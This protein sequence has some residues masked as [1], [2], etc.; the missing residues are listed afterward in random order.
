M[1]LTS[2]RFGWPCVRFA[3]WV[4]NPPELLH[5]VLGQAPA[6]FASLTSQ[7]VSDLMSRVPVMNGV[8]QDGA[9]V[10]GHTGATVEANA[11]DANKTR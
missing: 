7:K 1:R 4:E 10:N 2:L 5:L 6:N 11:Q 8:P 9:G 3:L